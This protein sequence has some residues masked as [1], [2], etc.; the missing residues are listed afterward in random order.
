MSF[1]MGH[2]RWVVFLGQKEARYLRILG[3]SY[4]VLSQDILAKTNDVPFVVSV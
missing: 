1:C 3:R 4:L 2:N